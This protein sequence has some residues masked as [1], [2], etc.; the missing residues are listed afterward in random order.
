MWETK[1]KK[2][3]KGG[4]DDECGKGKGMKNQK[5]ER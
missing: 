3:N 4:K 5:V 1:G 2:W